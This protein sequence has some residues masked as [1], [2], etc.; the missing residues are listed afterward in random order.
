MLS[1]DTVEIEIAQVRPF[2]RELFVS[3]GAEET[4]RWADD[5]GLLQDVFAAAVRLARA[6]DP[7][8]DVEV[9][10]PEISGLD[11]EL[12]MG[13]RVHLKLGKAQWQLVLLAIPLLVSAVTHAVSATELTG[14]IT[15]MLGAIVAT[16]E[17]IDPHDWP[18]FLAVKRGAATRADVVLKLRT[19][20]T[21]VDRSVTHLLTQGVLAEREGRLQVVV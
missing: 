18:V 8:V 5:R 10:D 11:A 17:R 2:M 9:T 14:T 20:K 13:R 3:A 1:N 7:D 4:L 19:T 16:L 6:A 15:A 12:L 21:A